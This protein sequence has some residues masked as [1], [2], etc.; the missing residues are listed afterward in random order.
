MSETS[1]KTQHR[2]N[3]AQMFEQRLMKVLTSPRL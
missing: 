3:D 1:R 2:L